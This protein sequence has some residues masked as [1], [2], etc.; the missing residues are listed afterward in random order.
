[1]YLCPYRLGRR[2]YA[3]YLIKNNK[4]IIASL[5]MIKTADGLL[6][7]LRYQISLPLHP[8][9]IMKNGRALPTNANTAGE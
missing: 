1:M 6:N 7:H 9:T 2:F 4:K 5:S 3:K 8:I